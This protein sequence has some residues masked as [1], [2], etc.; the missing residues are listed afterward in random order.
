MHVFKQDSRN[1]KSIAWTLLLIWVVQIVT[2]TVVFAGGGGPTQPEVQGFTP[3]G[4]SDMVDPFTGDFTYNIPLMNI[5][6]YPVNIA[7]NSGVSMDQ[8]A[9]WVGLG[10]NLNMGAIV[11]SMRGLPD[12]FNGDEI[13]K[14]E[15][16]KPNINVGLSA[17]LSPELFAF[18]LKKLKE[19]DSLDDL[20]I[21]ANLGVNYSNYQGWGVNFSVGP[22]FEIGKKLGVNV[23]FDIS[24]SS[25]NGPGFSPN[26]N[27]SKLI[28]EKNNNSASL[29]LQVGS[30]FNSREGLQYL[31][32]GASLKAKKSGSKKSYADGLNSSF[33]YG[34]NT[35]SPTAGPNMIGTT[36]SAS[37]SF[38]GTFLWMDGQYNISANYSQQ[39]IKDKLT[40]A[41]AFGYLYHQNGV[42]KEGN[43]TPLLDFNRDNDG[44][45]TKNTPF[46]PSAFQTYD[47]FSVQAQGVGGS[48]RPYRN[49]VS[50]V[51]DPE[52]VSTNGSSSFGFELGG[53]N[54]ADIGADISVNATN[55]RS[56]VWSNNNS[57]RDYLGP[58]AAADR[59]PIVSFVEANE[60]AVDVENLQ[61]YKFLNNTNY[62][63]SINELNNKKT[64][65]KA[66]VG[67]Q[68][69]TSNKRA[70]R[71]R[72]NN[73]FQFIT[74][75][76]YQNGLGLYEYPTNLTT[77][78]KPHHIGE[79]T[80]LGTDGRRYVFGLPAYNYYQED[81]TFS[82]GANMAGNKPDYSLNF[83]TGW[84][85][86]T[87]LS[88]LASLEN[89]YGVD[90]YYSSKITPAYAHSFM[91]SAVLSDDYS[92]VDDIKGP[93]KG[94]F[95]S[96]VAFDY[97]KVDNHEWRTPMEENTAYFNEGLK[98][99]GHDDKASFVHGKKE[100]WYVKKVETKNYIA[101]FHFFV[102]KDGYSSAGRNGGLAIDSTRAMKGLAKIVLYTK[103]EYEKNQA[104]ATPIQTV[105]FNYDYSRCPTYPG[106]INTQQGSTTATETGKLTLLS[107][108]VTY[109]K[110][111][112]MK[113]RKYRF[114][115]NSINPKYNLK[116]VDRWGVYKPTGN[117]ST[118]YSLSDPL[119]NA[120]FP[121]TLQTAITNDYASAW[122][123]TDIH[124]PT[125]GKIH[126]D[127]ESDDYGYV[128]HKRAHKMIPISGIA[129]Y[130][131]NGNPHIDVN[132]VSENGA[133]KHVLF[134]TSVN[135]NNNRNRPILFKLDDNN[136]DVSDYVAIGQQIYFRVL[137]DFKP[138]KPDN[139]YG[140]YDYVS[141]YGE[142]LEAKNEWING[143]KY[144]YIRFK[145][146]KLMENG[147]DNY[148]IIAKAAILFG[149]MN[150]SRFIY[151][152]NAPGTENSDEN[153]LKD[154]GLAFVNSFV[155]FKD[156]FSGPNMPI[157][158]K[159]K[160]VS[161]VTEK[162]WIRTLEPRKKK[163]GGGVR[164]KR[165][166]IYDNWNLQTNNQEAGYY[167][168]QEFKYELEDGTSSGVASYEPMLGG[169]ENPWHQPVMYVNE[170]KWAIDDKLFQETPLMES[171][172][173]SPSIGYSRVEI[174]DIKRQGVKKTATGK[175]VK[176]FYTSRDFPTFVATSEIDPIF[177]KSKLSG[178]FFE[179]YE[180][181]TASQG[182]TIENNDMNGKPK[183]EGVYAEGVNVPLSEVSYHYA[184][185][186]IGVVDGKPIFRLRNDA[187]TINEDGTTQ[188][189]KIGVR[190]D[191]VADFR[192]S[193]TTSIAKKVD[194][195]FTS[196]VIGIPFFIAL[197]LLNVDKSS[198]RMR[199]ATLNK[200]VQRFGI[201][202]QVVARQD[203]SIVA[204]NNK[205]YDARTGEVLLTQT[206]TDFNDSIYSLNYPAYW[207][208]KL[209]GQASQNIRYNYTI[210]GTNS[211]GFTSLPANNQFVEGDEVKVT[212]QG[213]IEKAWVKE[214][215]VLGI[216]LI[217]QNGTPI[218]NY[219]QSNIEVIR[220]GYRNKQTTSMASLTA[221]KN[222]IQGL[223]SNQFESVVNA[224]AIEMSDDWKTSCNC[225]NVGTN[226]YVNATKGNFRPVRS[227]TYLTGRKQTAYDLNTNIRRDGVFTAFSPYYKNVSGSWEKNPA[228]WT[229]VS[230]VTAFSPNGMT[231]ETKDALNRF[232]ASSF[233]FNNT[234]TTA[235]AANTKKSQF[236]AIDFE[237]IFF[238]KGCDN[239]QFFAIDTN[240]VTVTNAHTGRNAINVAPN[241]QIEF[242][243][244]PKDCPTSDCNITITKKTAD[245]LAINGALQP[246]T[247]EFEF[248]A[249]SPGSE[250][251]DFPVYV[252]EFNEIQMDTDGLGV[253]PF[254][255]ML[256][257]IDANGCEVNYLLKYDGDGA[258]NLN[259][260]ALT[261]TKLN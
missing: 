213:V 243:T 249:F 205:A 57:M 65:L 22:E 153:S 11:R 137:T 168:G 61:D 255:L 52:Q 167:Y 143:K 128:Q 46:L 12:D 180:H 37:F 158:Q 83:Q 133:P 224:G 25:E 1:T 184:Q 146:E 215:N 26:V 40:Y 41:S 145:G 244:V 60:K 54:A 89:K 170:K 208:Y 86:T 121:Y 5:D 114:D 93:S 178:S 257:L 97:E 183:W 64:E 238:N 227:Y 151:D 152:I 226:P 14:T 107:I 261:I 164:V 96:Y 207:K 49:E 140:K 235:V 129:Y 75:E 253:A 135:H 115:Y 157:Y 209:L 43:K 42:A 101:L 98:I 3:V 130:D 214:K 71:L 165:I 4:V 116:A 45:F 220:S 20:Q 138:D 216:I 17:K 85:Q 177:Q 8:E 196:A 242:T 81:A 259:A 104:N 217:K 232:S 131:G 69:I 102:R 223:L 70:Q 166:S 163:K 21:N 56:G 24:G 109:Q 147:S 154:L 231:L 125:G 174:T 240:K 252:N 155:S 113:S 78:A 35:Y 39:Q 188:I 100:L 256:H 181:L 179:K 27:F 74:I 202:E 123:L 99:D 225:N 106:N 182:F 32:Y 251:V 195:N 186:S 203:G 160:G 124:L 10:W 51:Y 19:N 233:G 258:L 122:H 212:H 92:D 112:K 234:L 16:M 36:V 148:S 6:G 193:E 176:E 150:L 80:Q 142:V 134:S 108:E 221:L 68:E 156:I 230:E 73:E 2:P 199:S 103:P 118:D 48:F 82:V 161:F 237:D 169:D 30:G 28:K 34:L 141:G 190:S 76:E 50:Y 66:L 84:F 63:F 117:S 31:S 44:T 218:A 77:T 126:V 260:P 171:Q 245:K 91:L 110:S 173:P 229:F 241:T 127:Y 95:G 197:M 250:I 187:L 192:E 222:P 210:N 38:T 246:I 9:S 248:L 194:L 67:G 228:N 59:L 149:R 185:D 111:K 247:F 105:K 88:E 33:D 72:T 79:I 206:T 144:G 239:S 15:K 29:G 211:I 201:L 53:G 219:G 204:T 172:F 120:D 175:V 62:N 191:V 236:A 139:D 90:E 58:R 119:T 7:Y 23:G 13:S 47:I 132:D 55:S 94:D 162:S 189:N 136:D 87:S 200:T 198:T 159:E 18:R 254:K